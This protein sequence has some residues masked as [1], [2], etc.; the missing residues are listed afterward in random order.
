MT[1]WMHSLT[2]NNGKSQL[3]SKFIKRKM[4]I[5]LIQWLLLDIENT[6]KMENEMKE[7]IMVLMKNLMKKF[8]YIHQELQ[9]FRPN[10]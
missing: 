3:L 4:V 5:K 8:L 6:L 9:F 2:I 7:N 1:T 10:Q